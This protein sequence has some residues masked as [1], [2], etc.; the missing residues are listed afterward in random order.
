MNP[1]DQKNTAWPK[2][3]H[4]QCRQF[5]AACHKP[6]QMMQL[7]HKKNVFHTRNSLV[8]MLDSIVREAGMSPSDYSW[9]SF[10]RGAAVFAFELGLQ[11]SAVQLLGDW[12]SDAFKNY[13]EFAHKEKSLIAKEI[14]KCF[15]NHVKKVG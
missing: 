14:A 12:S 11:D 7:V 4:I 10:R 3:Y 2:L 1:I 8:K 6:L 9:H 13:L 15:D 5:R